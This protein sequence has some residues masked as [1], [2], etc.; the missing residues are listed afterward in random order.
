MI[1]FIT[2]NVLRKV[3]KVLTLLLRYLE[4]VDKI[5]KLQTIYLSVSNIFTE[6]VKTTKKESF[7]EIKTKLK[8]YF[9][10]IINLKTK[11][12]HGSLRNETPRVMF[13]GDKLTSYTP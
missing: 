3:N 11:R 8:N 13:V 5:K 9:P 4:I 6:D 7:L 1:I 12:Q 2:K 10:S